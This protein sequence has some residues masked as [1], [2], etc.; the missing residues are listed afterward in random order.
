MTTCTPGR[1]QALADL[2]A[3]AWF[4]IGFRPRDSVVVVGMRQARLAGAVARI[5]RPPRQHE[6]AAV[7]ALVQ[8]LRRT[9]DTGVVVLLVSDR[10]QTLPHTRLARRLADGFAAD[11]FE[12]LDVVQVGQ[13]HFAS[14]LCVDQRCC[15]ATG[16]PLEAVAVSSVAADMVLRGRSCVAAEADLVADVRPTPNAGPQTTDR[17]TPP[18]APS[19]TRGQRSTWLRLWLKQMQRPGA[20]VGT[21][22][23]DWLEVA[24]ADHTTRDAFLVT[25]AKPGARGAATARALLAGQLDGLAEALSGEVPDRG[26][27]ERARILLAAVARQAAPGQRAEALAALAWMSW[28]VGEAARARLLCELALQDRPGHRLAALVEQL[29]SHAI[30]PPWLAPS[31]GPGRQDRLA[32][33]EW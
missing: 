18:S 26:V 24:L 23:V 27:A 13:R 10:P 28:W 33:S 11:G 6:S 22:Q 5:D 19:V 1:P 9:G 30:P 20:T 14:Y 32:A 3:Y 31:N 7:E 8:P 29:L 17:A 4:Q 25:I 16:H 15:P 12:V 2:I 21:S